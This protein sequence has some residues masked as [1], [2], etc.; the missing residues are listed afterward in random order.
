MNWEVRTMRSGNCWF[1]APLF[2]KNAARFWPLWGAYT[3]IL[4]LM[5]PLWFLFGN[6]WTSMNT[7]AYFT[8]Y[9][10]EL[11]ANPITSFLYA[12]LLAMA[13]WSFLYNFRAVGS[14]H[15]LPL[16]RET[17]F[18]TNYITGLLFFLLPNLLIFAL[19][20][21]CQS[22]VGAV[23]LGALGTWLWTQT[24][25]M[26]CFYS[27]ATFFAFVT[28]NLLALPALYVIFNF[29][30]VGILE[31]LDEIFRQ[32]VFGYS[33]SYLLSQAAE[34]VT[35]MVMILSRVAPKREDF[36]SVPTGIAGM[37]YLYI[38]ALAGL[39]FAGLALLLYR[40]H[41]VETAGEFV[42]VPWLRPVFK[43]GVGLC[44]ALVF[45]SVSY[46][47]FGI[48]EQ[49]AGGFVTML[50]F[51]L[52]WGVLFYLGTAMLIQKSVRVFKGERLG[53]AILALV[54]ILGMGAMKLDLFGVETRVPKPDEIASVSGYGAQWNINTRLG[55]D[56]QFI[57]EVSRFH[58]SVVAQ[59]GDILRLQNSRR[60]WAEADDLESR[61]ISIQYQLKNGS[62]LK[63]EYSIPVSREL[64][65][66]EG[67]P[68][69]AYEAL[70]NLPLSR[71]EN[72]LPSAYARETLH[73]AQLS[74]MMETEVLGELRLQSRLDWTDYGHSNFYFTREEALRLYDAVYEDL[75]AGRM[76]QKYML[77]GEESSKTIAA[78]LMFSFQMPNANIESFWIPISTESSTT[79]AFLE[80]FGFQR[81]VDLLTW[82]EYGLLEQA[83][84]G[85]K[86]GDVP[87]ERKEIPVIPE[88]VKETV[89]PEA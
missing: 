63:R 49:L 56:P 72:T 4:F 53:C 1:S 27:I 30:F 62:I 9:V 13:L 22:A 71:L 86:Y 74:S 46:S 75:Q 51:L 68:A 55:T 42:A 60:S 41:K 50:L 11:A 65:A 15:A 12:I 19:S 58:Q 40:R 78:E 35:P 82:A 17:I 66:Q 85:E 69:A 24:L 48:Q 70:V 83:Y 43:Y 45:A 26:L 87:L 20:L 18:V 73:Q 79:L 59:K 77:W 54:L 47:V 5:L 61:Y 67:S 25:M 21:L 76:G 6:N 31:F 7:Q 39:V 88:A 34:H 89:Q 2:K 8:S 28:G 10:M 64:L 33:S 84:Y 29:L 81:G 80:E 23:T 16:R 52:F 14:I 3:L 37:H 38:Y 57:E 36:E 32:F 44:G